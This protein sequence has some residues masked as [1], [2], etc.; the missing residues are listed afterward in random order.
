MS[1]QEILAKAIQKAVEGYEATQVGRLWNKKTGKEVKGS[2]NHKGYRYISV[3]LPETGKSKKITVHKLVA[4][5]HIPNPDNLPHIN[6][7]DGNRLNNAAW[8]LEWCT[9]S[10]NVSD[11][12]TRG[13]VIWNKNNMSK[14]RILS[15]AKKYPRQVFWYLT[16]NDFA[17]AK[18][19]WGNKLLTGQMI[20]PFALPAW[21]CH[22]RAMVIADDPI[23]YLGANI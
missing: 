23:Q 8:N 4:L 16:A 15:Y 18:A 14:E 22:L 7:K 1:D 17:A 19:L 10:Y 13:R 2:I 5:A 21:K 12:F 20:E 9:A 6:H 3:Y 11:G